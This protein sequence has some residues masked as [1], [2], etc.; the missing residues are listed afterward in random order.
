MGLPFRNLAGKRF[1]MLTAVSTSKPGPR[2]LAMWNCRCDCG[3][4]TVVRSNNLLTGNTKTCG[5]CGWKR[6][7]RGNA[8]IH[9][10]AI[11]HGN[12]DPTYRV[13][14]GMKDRCS[15][16]NNAKYPVYG[17]RGIKV[18]ERW[19]DFR[20]FLADVGKRPSLKHSI[21]R[22][23][24]NDGNYELSNFRWATTKQQAANRHPRN[25]HLHPQ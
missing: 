4:K 8:L 1:G 24:D 20:N 7:A 18:C 16:P 9:G 19:K 21:D 14:R 13:W 25:F 22:F 15:N 5:P 11:G 3:N 12:I 6:R 10:H 2:G 23:P 17:G